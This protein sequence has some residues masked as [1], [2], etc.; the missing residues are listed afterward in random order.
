MKKCQLKI[1]QKTKIWRKNAAKIWWFKFSIKWMNQSQ[2][3]N[4][5]ICIFYSS[6]ISNLISIKIRLKEVIEKQRKCT[7][8]NRT[9]FEWKKWKKSSKSGNGKKALRKKKTEWIWKRLINIPTF[10]VFA[11][12][13]KQ[14]LMRVFIMENALSVMKRLKRE[15]SLFNWNALAFIIPSALNGELTSEISAAHPVNSL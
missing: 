13:G 1:S 4:L 8:S 12:I 11:M 6:K 5:E 9:G 3:T 15:K 2:W 7:R 14:I 10:M